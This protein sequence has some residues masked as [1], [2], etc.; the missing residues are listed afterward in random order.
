MNIYTV[1]T[2]ASPSEKPRPASGPRWPTGLLPWGTT[3]PR[4]GNREAGRTDGAAPG[5][6]KEPFR[7]TAS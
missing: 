6:G 7:P 2:L 3:S 1:M 4:T 5:R